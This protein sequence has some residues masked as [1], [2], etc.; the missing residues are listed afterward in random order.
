M[1]KLTFPIVYTNAN[2]TSTIGEASL[3]DFQEES[4]GG[5]ADPQFNLRQFKGNVEIVFA[6]LPANWTG[7]WHE[8]PKPQWIIPLSGGWWVETQ[9]G[10]RIEL[11]KGDISFGADQNTE[12][13]KDG[14]KGHRSGSLDGKPCYMMIVQLLDESWVG[15]TPENF[16]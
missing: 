15:A 10:K 11:R 12:K 7:E 16:E 5:D 3:S 1:P 6:Q 4:M 14:N 13:N 9:D 2:G 8:N